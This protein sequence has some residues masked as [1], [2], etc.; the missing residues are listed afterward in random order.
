M[1]SPNHSVLPHFHFVTTPEDRSASFSLWQQA[2]AALFA[3]QEDDPDIIREFNIDV[4]IYN[5]GPMLLG[6][7]ELS[8]QRF[9]R[10]KDSIRRDGIDHFLLLLCKTISFSG[11]C[12]GQVI[13]MQ[14][15]DI[16]LFSLNKPADTRSVS[17]QCLGVVLPRALLAPLLQ[18]PEALNAT[19]L[20]KGS[21]MCDFLFNHMEQLLINATEIKEADAAE[22]A[23]STAAMIAVCFG[24][25]SGQSVADT[26][27]LSRATLVAMRHFIEEN[28]ASPDLGAELMVE[29]FP[30]S[31]ATLY[32]QFAS[33]GGIAQF[34]RKR[35]LR[36]A[37]QQLTHARNRKIKI[38]DV[39]RE[40]GFS[41]AV[42]FSR[43]FV[44]EY[45]LRP[46]D[47]RNKKPLPAKALADLNDNQKVS[48]SDWLYDLT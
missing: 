40:N 41:S 30:V 11:T 38:E 6:G 47:A 17:G 33:L 1:P 14:P 20:P 48:V 31:R 34:I 13:N 25:G 42:T 21:V 22:L 36:R 37:L 27:R 45:D 2:R 16:G 4:C 12:D 3:P 26:Y 7:G 18:N 29:K 32:R 28:L 39:A 23:K 24:Q 35:R 8:A 19:V 15:G 9:Y 10:T 46:M 44:A 43:A 5:A